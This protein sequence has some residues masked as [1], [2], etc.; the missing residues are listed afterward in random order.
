VGTNV[1]TQDG[2]SD[3][4]KVGSKVGPSVTVGKIG[5][6]PSVEVIFNEIGL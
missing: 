2:L 5:P 1:G 3:G 4:C 6:G